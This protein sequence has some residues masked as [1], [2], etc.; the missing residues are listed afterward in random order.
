MATERVETI[1]LVNNG[2][3]IN[4]SSPAE[5]KNCNSEDGKMT[6]MTVKNRKPSA[7]QDP[8]SFRA[9]KLIQEK[10]KYINIALWI[11]FVV[12]FLAL[13]LVL[14]HWVNDSR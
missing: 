5:A 7:I 2:C 1:D 11:V 8:E 9:G 10:I 13:L 14:I 12:G 4:K 6:L 3:D